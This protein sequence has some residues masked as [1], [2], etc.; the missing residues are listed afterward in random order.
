MEILSK[1]LSIKKNRRSLFASTLVPML[2]SGGFYLCFVWMAIFMKD[3]VPDPPIPGAFAINSISLFLSL[4]LTFP[5]SGMLSDYLGRKLVM[6]IGALLLCV[7]GPFMLLLISR[8]NPYVAFIAQCALGIYLALWGS[9][10]MAWLAESFPPETRLTAVSI[11]YN[12]SQAIAGGTAPALATILV[13]KFDGG[14]Y[15]ALAPGC[16]LTFFG[17]LALIGL[18]IAPTSIDSIETSNTLASDE[19][20]SDETVI[21]NGDGVARVNH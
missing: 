8:G 19:H 14:K 1:R 17:T 7:T 16:I 18:Y 20:E 2:W 10:M 12:M 15:A 21:L 3:L 9:P 5:L 13:D 4:C 11:G 6:T